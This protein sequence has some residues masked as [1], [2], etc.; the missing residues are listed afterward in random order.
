MN[1]E[2]KMIMMMTMVKGISQIDVAHFPNGKVI[3]WIQAKEFS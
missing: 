2:L 3:Q 1:N